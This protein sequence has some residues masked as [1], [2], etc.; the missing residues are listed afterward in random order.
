MASNNIKIHQHFKV[1]PTSST[2][3]TTTIKPLTYFDLFWLRFHPVERVFFYTLPVSQSHPSFFFQKLVPKFK[4]SLSL[5]LQ[6]FLPLAGRIVWPSDSP[7][8]FIQFNL[9]DNDDGVSLLIAES[10]LDFNHVIENSP[11]EA[12]L[13][14]SL[15]PF[16]ESTDSF[17]SVL[18]IQVT[19]FPES[20]F[21]IGISTHHAVLDGKSSTMFI[22]AWAYLCN[23]IIKTEEETPTLLPELEP[24]F[25]RVII[26]DRNELEVTLTNNWMDTMT[27]LFPNE[28]GNKRCLKILPFEPKL[29]DC[30][31][32]TFKLTREDL[33]K[34]NKR[35][36]STWEIFNTNE[37]KPRNLSSFVLTCAYSLVC[38]AKAFQGVEKERKKF[39]FAFTIDCR[40]RL[41][42]PI[43]NNYFGNCVL[44]H[45]IN[46]QP[47]DF[48]KEDGLN[49]V[50]KS[51]Y[52]QI[53]LIKEK[54]VF[55]G[56]KDVFAK[57]TC[58]AS[59]G[60]E[61]IGVAGSNRFGVYETDFGW[62][63]P[64]KVEI[65]S[66]DRGLTIG[67]AESKDGN[68]GIEIGLVLNKHVM[69]LF[70]TLFLEGL[71]ID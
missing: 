20:G 66:I 10:D 58:L 69:D 13:S 36:L 37:S 12:S 22:K 71:S 51:I 4:S 61:I 41:E 57:Y 52:D 7:K 46:T 25:N 2:Q 44:G 24:L 54:G 42:P 38:I 45:F 34:L 70:R 3:I 27:K 39:T 47:L 29:K 5:T 21:S 43:P 65:V 63:M 32:A 30:V 53:K 11:Q 67:L 59:E 56:I 64:E 14:R 8:P 33:N 49:L 9:N 40:S 18:S 1:V 6:H 48:I 15:I 35:V 16:L 23:K 26:K 31:R 62:G 17:A 50:T 55:E 60:V 68:G 19:L 28:K